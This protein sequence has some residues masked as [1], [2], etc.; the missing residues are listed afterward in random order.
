MSQQQIQ[1]FARPGG[2]QK[3]AETEKFL[4]DSTRS[5]ATPPSWSQAPI[6][7][8]CGSCTR[9]RLCCYG[10]LALVLV[11]I[12]VI[13]GFVISIFSKPDLSKN[14]G[15]WESKLCNEGRNPDSLDLNGSYELVSISKNFGDYLAAMG[16]P[17]FVLPMA[18]RMKETIT[19]AITDAGFDAKV[20]NDW[21]E[22]D[23]YFGF[24]QVSNITYGR[25]NMQGIMWNLCQRQ[26]HNLILCRST[27]R[28]KGWKIT[29]LLRFTEK[30]MCSERTFVNKGIT[31]KRFYKKEGVELDGFSLPP[32]ATDYDM[33]ADNDDDDDD[34]DMS[35]D[36]SEEDNF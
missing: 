3:G 34:W 27:E 2:Q 22:Q 5:L 20:V 12:L 32:P 35:F 8:R 19:Y 14:A 21:K 15:E 23:L 9:R 17:S 1:P 29:N 10:C 24:G 28:E 13:A 30:G 18:L 4:P 7:G 36:S 6:K 11:I 31:A 26:Q 33:F 25:G 16:V